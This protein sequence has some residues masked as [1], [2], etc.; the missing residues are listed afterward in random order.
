[1]NEIKFSATRHR[2]SDNAAVAI[3]VILFKAKQT[4]NSLGSRNHSLSQRLLRCGCEHVRSE[5]SPK[6]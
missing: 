5:Y 2:I 1:M 4:G 3:G 6:I